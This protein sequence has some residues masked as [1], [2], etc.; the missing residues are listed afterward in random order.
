MVY[1]FKEAEKDAV[2][3]EK[4]NNVTL[5]EKS[6]NQDPSLYAD[7]LVCILQIQVSYSTPFLVLTVHFSFP[8]SRRQ[9]MHL[10]HF[11]SLQMLGLSGHGT[12]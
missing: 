11:W 10:K 9:K 12:R 2:I 6:V 7:K 3:D 1:A 5:E 8:F 4:V